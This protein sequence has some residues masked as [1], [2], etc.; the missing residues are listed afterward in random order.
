MFYWRRTDALEA[1]APKPRRVALSAPAVDVM[2]LSLSTASGNDHALP[3]VIRTLPQAELLHRA[4]VGVAAKQNGHSS[5][6]SGCDER[7]NPLKGSHEHAHVLPLDLDDDGHLEHILIW[8]PM[9]LDAAAQAVVRAMR[10][11][12]AKGGIGSLK[13]AL[14][15]AGGLDDLRRIPGIY[16]DGLRALLG[17]EEGMAEWISLT[18]FVPPRHLKPRGKNSLEGQIAAEL[19]SRGFPEPLEV[20]VHDLRNEHWLRFR[21]FVRTR[22]NGRAAPIDCGFSIRVRLARP[23]PGPL[24]LGYGSHFGLGLFAAKTFA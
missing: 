6:L 24:C 17:P 13:L 21:H 14:E 8:A 5:V 2:L 4:L 15:A 19:E 22:R 16:G 11:T 23:V 10:Q 7:G 20:E 1:G 18:P 12:F 9:R 3:N